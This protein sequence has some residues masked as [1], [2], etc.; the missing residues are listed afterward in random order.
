[1]NAGEKCFMWV[2]PKPRVF[3]M[4]PEQIKD[5]L[6]KTSLFRKPR[7]GSRGLRG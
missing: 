6:T 7:I 2:G 4:D 1:M 5:I 3:I